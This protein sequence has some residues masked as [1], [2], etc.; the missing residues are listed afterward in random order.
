MVRG[1]GSE[2]S[3]FEVGSGSKTYPNSPMALDL[4]CKPSTS[5]V[6]NVPAFTPAPLISSNEM[7]MQQLIQQP[8]INNSPLTLMSYLMKTNM[9]G[10]SVKHK[11]PQEENERTNNDSQINYSEINNVLI[12]SEIKNDQ[13]SSNQI[14]NRINTD[15]MQHRQL[16]ISWMN[17]IN[18]SHVNQANAEVINSNQFNSSASNSPLPTGQSISHNHSISMASNTIS[19]FPPV[20][21]M[22]TSNFS[23]SSSPQAS[24]SSQASST[25]PFS[26][27]QKSAE[28]LKAIRTSARPFKAYPRDPLVLS[29][30][31]QATSNVYNKFRKE[32]LEQVRHTENESTN[33]KM[34]R[35][36]NRS[37]SPTSSTTDKDQAY[38]E[39]RKK[40]NAAAKRSRDNRRVKE[41]ELAVRTAFLEEQ[42]MKLWCGMYKILKIAKQQNMQFDR[43]E[44]EG[45]ECLLSVLITLDTED[46][47]P[48]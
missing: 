48:T 26:D 14:N 25:M 47:N 38:L 36:P 21:G 44:F 24:S 10:F 20:N 40:N 6:V 27:V 42:N 3:P 9:G 8:S 41:D 39:R 4:S 34:R 32:I 45:N 22:E 11:L 12:N 5:V 30:G 18:S 46:E 2:N 15:R 43:R 17:H 29:V 28:I 7:N 13:T 23:S 33:S 1:E 37:G 16:N 19:P 35:T 31:S